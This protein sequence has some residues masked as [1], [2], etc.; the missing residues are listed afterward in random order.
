MNKNAL[1]IIW[2]QFPKSRAPKCDLER[3]HIARNFAEAKGLIPEKVEGIKPLIQDIYMSVPIEDTADYCILVRRGEKELLQPKLKARSQ[4][5]N[6][7][8]QN[9]ITE[10]LKSFVKE[11][12][13]MIK[14]NNPKIAKINYEDGFVKQQKTVAPSP[15]TFGELP[16]YDDYINRMIDD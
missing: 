2:V 1:S 10:D 6:I 15:K 7:S 11:F 8:I 14:H 16:N 13:K 4:T 9:S 3:A 5:T 12:K